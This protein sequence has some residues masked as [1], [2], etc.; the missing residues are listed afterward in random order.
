MHPVQ[1]HSQYVSN[2]KFTLFITHHMTGAVNIILKS[3]ALG[4]TGFPHDFK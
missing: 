1:V 2:S 3:V 4:V